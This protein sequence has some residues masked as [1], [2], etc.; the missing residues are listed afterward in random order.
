[1][2]IDIHDFIMAAIS[3][4]II[5]MLAVSITLDSRLG[6]W[7]WVVCQW[8]FFRVCTDDDCKYGILFPIIPLTGWC[9][10]YIPQQYGKIFFRKGVKK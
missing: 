7:N 1:M 10:D 5:M 2:F 4:F 3:L 8:F 6:W 9:S